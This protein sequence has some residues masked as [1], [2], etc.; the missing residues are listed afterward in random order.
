MKTILT[1]NYENCK[2]GN[3]I[4]ISKD[5]GK[6][7]NFNGLTFPKL[8]PK[9]DLGNFDNID[10]LEGQYDY[11]K[12]YYIDVLSKLDP[13]ELFDT[14]LDYSIIIDYDVNIYRHLIA[15]WLELFLDIKTFEVEVNPKRDTFKAL[16]RP[17]YL[18]YILEDI[19]RQN[20]NMGDYESINAAYLF[21]KSKEKE[22]EYKLTIKN[23]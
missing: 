13:Q 16:N 6:K 12:S 10:D 9:Q 21:N 11:I 3:L 15:F 8:K 5:N 4:S 14:F 23:N 22:K 1:G 20:Y 2:T 17:D 18:K 19:I 7:A